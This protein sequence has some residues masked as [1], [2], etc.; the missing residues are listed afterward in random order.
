MNLILLSFLS[1]LQIV[2]CQ[3]QDWNYGRWSKL[4]FTVIFILKDCL[5]VPDPQWPVSTGRQPVPMAS[6]LTRLPSV[7]EI[8]TARMGQMSLLAVSFV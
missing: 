4:I 2:K 3:T 5:R 7:M 6:V 8:W 1:T